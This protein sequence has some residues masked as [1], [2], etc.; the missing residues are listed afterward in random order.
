MHFYKEKEQRSMMLFWVET[1]SF[2]RFLSWLFFFCISEKRMRLGRLHNRSTGGVTQRESKLVMTDG[3]RPASE[4]ILES[5]GA[6]SLLIRGCRSE[7]TL[8]F[9]LA[10]VTVKP[11]GQCRNQCQ[12]DMTKPCGPSDFPPCIGGT[13][14][15][16]IQKWP[17]LGDWPQQV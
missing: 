4:N 14:S 15:V 6:K 12:L 2:W 13:M 10:K 16:W 1:G 11:W 9:H 3:P 5:N 17:F 7:H 8:I